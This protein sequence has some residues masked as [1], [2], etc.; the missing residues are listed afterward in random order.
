MTHTAPTHSQRWNRAISALLS[1]SIP[2]SGQ[3]YSGKT[4]PAL[5]WLPAVVTAY[6]A[7][8]A[9]GVAAHGVCIF[10]AIE[11]DA[12]DPFQESSETQT[13]K[14]AVY[15]FSAMVFAVVLFTLLEL[16]GFNPIAGS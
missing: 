15:V 1:L 2:G 16:L 9:L 10:D 4:V 14:R 12:E 5:I 11:R 3:L 6:L 8:P 13:S 7:L